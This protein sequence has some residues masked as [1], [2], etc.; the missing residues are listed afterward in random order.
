MVKRALSSGLYALLW[1]LAWP[2]VMA[3]I[4][5]R[6]RREPAYRLQPGQRL[7]FGP[8]L[9]PLS[10]D[11]APRVWLHAVSLGET[12][13][14]VPLVD[15]LRRRWPN[16]QLLL[17]TGTAT[18][19]Q[20]GLALLRPGD[21]HRWVPLDTPGAPVRFLSRTQ[22]S[23]AVLMETET[24]PHLVR[25]TQAAGVPLVLANARLSERSLRKARRWPSLTRPMMARV[26]AV[27]AQSPDDAQRLVQAGARPEAVQVVGNLKYDLAPDPALLARGQL[28]R[29][30]PWP[31]PATAVRPGRRIV[32]AASWR[33]G[34]DGPLLAAW[35]AQAD[36]HPGDEHRPLLLLV[37]RHPQRFDEV[38]VLLRAQGWRVHR[39]SAS[40]AGFDSEAAG[41]ADVWLGDSLGEMAA[42]AAAADV[43][44]LGGSFAPL[45]GQNLIEIAAC[46]CALI[47]GPH[48]FN[49]QEAAQSACEVGAAQRAS[50]L[51]QAVQQAWC[52]PDA[53]LRRMGAAGLGFAGSHRGATGRM[54]DAIVGLAGGQVP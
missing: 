48:T 49:F 21:H 13:A 12:R 34:E 37:P 45:G 52:L 7:G 39:R 20:A 46:G 43:A 27:L 18:G 24:W 14:A 1:C 54:A 5:W 40:P 53:E 16:M 38:Q 26:A 35:R 30:R 17:T 15:A 44:L 19:W 25:A 42:Y 50:D 6:G 2:A 3:R 28:W 32:L 11:T 31:G 23:I 29:S 33:E 36:A 10:A 22:P 9:P 41:R 8:L 47:L 4:W 51:T